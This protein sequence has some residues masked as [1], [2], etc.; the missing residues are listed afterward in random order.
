MKAIQKGFTL[1]ELMIV[2]AIIAILAAIALPAYQ[3]Y[4]VRSK[5]SEALTTASSPKSLVSEAFES[6]GV[7]GVA[8]VANEFNNVRPQAEKSTKYVDNLEIDDATGAITVTLSQHSGFPTTVR[9][10]QLTLTPNV[11]QALIADGVE[12]AI[13]WACATSTN[14][15][16]TTRG[17]Q[18]TTPNNPLPSKYASSECR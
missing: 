15:A 9:G 11:Q 3:D 2:V 6:D 13:D 5:V 10:T 14:N 18:V 12:G 16:A 4:T 8:A 1:I 17:L 7:D